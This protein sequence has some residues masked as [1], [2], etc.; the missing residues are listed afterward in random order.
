M[1][2][3]VMMLTSSV[4]PE[5]NWFV[6]RILQLT[7]TFGFARTDTLINSLFSPPPVSFCRQYP[8]H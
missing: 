1:G 5:G 3:V 8:W 4:R 7:S 6:A 2:V